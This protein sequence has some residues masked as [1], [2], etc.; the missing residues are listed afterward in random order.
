M[1]CD[2]FVTQ[3]NEMHNFQINVLIKFFVYSTCTC[4]ETHGFIIRKT[5]CVC[6]F[7]M[8]S[9]RNHREDVNINQS[10]YISSHLQASNTPKYTA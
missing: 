4:F 7:C 2:K 8:V 6:N 3:N 1:Y 10:D 5:V 9:L